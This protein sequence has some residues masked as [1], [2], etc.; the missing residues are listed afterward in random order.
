MLDISGEITSDFSRKV[1][2][3][4]FLWTIV[5]GLR[6]ERLFYFVHICGY[7]IKLM[8]RGHSCRTNDDGMDLIV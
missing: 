1:C 8:T 5:N 6:C 7:F 4:D 2:C 3:I